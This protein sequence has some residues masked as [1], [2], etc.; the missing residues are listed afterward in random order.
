MR[1][2]GRCL[3][4]HPPGRDHGRGCV[5]EGPR[6]RIGATRWATGWPS[7]RPGT[8]SPAAGA[9]DEDTRP[10]AQ[11]RE[12]VIRAG[13]SEATG[14]AVRLTCSP[15]AG[16]GLVPAG[17]FKASNTGTT[18]WFGQRLAL[19][20]DGEYVRGAAPN[21]DSA[22]RGLGGKQDD[23][24]ADQAGAVYVFTRAGDSVEPTGLCEGV[25][26]GSLRRVRQRCRP[27]PVGPYRWSSVRTS[28]IAT[29]TK[30]TI[31]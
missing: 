5:S 4:V 2:D 15:A 22:A 16:D 21:E 14:H 30:G 1:R 11:R 27:R 26:H 23:D 6:P 17:S 25:E 9:L 3:C 31:L 12:A 7:A 29:A 13:R 20:G 24:S 8:S 19:S 28:K 10:Q 18:D